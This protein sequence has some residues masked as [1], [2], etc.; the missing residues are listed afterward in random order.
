ML[1]H[2]LVNGDVTILT[3]ATDVL[4]FSSCATKTRNWASN[5]IQLTN[6]VFFDNADSI[7]LRAHGKALE[8][9]ID[10]FTL[11]VYNPPAASV[12]SGRM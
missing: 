11:K 3:P 1:V 8:K 6:A 10:N 12:Y 9:K 7:A 2:K 4:H 5:T